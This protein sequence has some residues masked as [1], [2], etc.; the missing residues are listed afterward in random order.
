MVKADIPGLT[1]DRCEKNFDFEDYLRIILWCCYK[2]AALYNRREGV[3]SVA[4]TGSATRESAIAPCFMEAARL[5]CRPSFRTI[6]QQLSL[7]SLT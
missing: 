2:V 4:Q 1:N 5:C 3:C 6:G 7:C